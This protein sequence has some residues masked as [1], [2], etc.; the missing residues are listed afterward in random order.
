MRHLKSERSR[1]ADPSWDP[2]R[3]G[4]SWLTSLLLSL[5]WVVAWASLLLFWADAPAWAQTLGRVGVAALCL[6]ALRLVSRGFGGYERGVGWRFIVREHRSRWNGLGLWFC[7]GFVLLGVAG[8]LGIHHGQG[9]WVESLKTL[10]LPLV[11]CVSAGTFLGLMF[12][13]A[14]KFSIFATLS[15]CGVVIG[16]ASLVVVQ[17]VATGFQHEF[18]GRVRGVYAH[19]N[20]TQHNGIR[21]YRRY[22]SWLRTLPGVSGVSPFAYNV[23]A[24]APN[25]SDGKVA[26]A[27]V[28]VKGI[29]PQSAAQV[30]DLREH[31]LRGTG[32]AVPLETLKSPFIPEELPPVPDVMLPAVIADTPA[33]PPSSSG[34]RPRSPAWVDAQEPDP[35]VPPMPIDDW[36]DPPLEAESSPDAAGGAPGSENTILDRSRLPTVFVGS[37]LAKELELA[38]DDVVRLVTVVRDAGQEREPDYRLFRVAGVFHAGFQEYDSRLIY[39]HIAELQRAKYRGQNIVSGLD[40]RLDD[41]YQAPKV[42]A[43]LRKDLGPRY[44]VLEWQDLNE[45]LFSSIRTQKNVVTVLW[46]LVSFVASFNVLSALWTMVVRRTPE[47]AIIVSMGATGREVARM[48]QVTG[49]TIGLAGSVAGIL[50]GLMNCWLVQIYGYSLDPEVY[51]IE[52]LPVEVSVFQLIWILGL[53]LSFCYLATIPP[54]LRAARLRPVEGLRYE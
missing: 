48:F 5:L 11:F 1:S 31:L 37:A 30:I 34:R 51:F 15:I 3:S 6:L 43:A 42:G 49:L 35:A 44:S 9:A 41:P 27:S 12:L 13:L 47:I 26:S 10:Q 54:S 45:N 22:E 4:H 16:V 24:L 39:L 52:E 14:R 38:V 46:G 36:V 40:L 25:R 50:F 7:L 53:S 17:S 28:L 32:K 20:V 29:D 21:D 8:I 18:E 19:I 2:P 23:L 33:I